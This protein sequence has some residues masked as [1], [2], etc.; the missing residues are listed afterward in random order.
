M[1][2]TRFAR[3]TTRQDRV[4]VGHTFDGMPV[5]AAGEIVLTPM[6][7]LEGYYLVADGSIAKKTPNGL[8]HRAHQG[9]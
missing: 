2:Q 5:N 7:R 1:V 9:A 8:P 6:M 4:I 3:K